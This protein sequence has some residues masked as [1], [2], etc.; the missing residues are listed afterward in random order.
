MQTKVLVVGE[1]DDPFRQLG[2]GRVRDARFGIGEPA[3]IE[4]KLATQVDCVT[5]EPA[6][7]VE[8]AL[9]QS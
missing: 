9:N 7:E 1:L 3:R 2:C 6:R 8:P 4:T 5:S